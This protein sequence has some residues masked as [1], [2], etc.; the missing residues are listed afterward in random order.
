MESVQGEEGCIAV[1]ERCGDTG[2]EEVSECLMYWTGK[3]WQRRM[4][5]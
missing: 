5:L 2:L 3:T 1:G 4:E